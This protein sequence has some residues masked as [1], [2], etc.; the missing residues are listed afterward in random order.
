MLS[1]NGR[2]HETHNL[3]FRGYNPYV[4]GLETFIL[5]W[6]VGVQRKMVCILLEFRR[7]GSN[8]QVKIRETPATSHCQNAGYPVS[9]IQLQNPQRWS[10]FVWFQLFWQR[11]STL[12]YWFWKHLQNFC[13]NSVVG[14]SLNKSIPQPSLMAEK[15][16]TILSFFK[17]PI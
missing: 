15:G 12:V 2:N 10:F 3:I 17:F 14:V 1:W 8:Q 9:G 11:N 13:E 4:S 6:V 7:F 5:P 16:E